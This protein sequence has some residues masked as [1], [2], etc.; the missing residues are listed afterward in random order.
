M[1]KALIF[2]TA[3]L[4]VGTVVA[5]LV[6]GREENGAAQSLKTAPIGREDL[7]RVVLATGKVE[8]LA[9][10]ELKSRASGVVDHQT[11]RSGM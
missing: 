4:L 1:K 6:F 8:P 5:Y 3:A 7:A 2:T 11:F 9:R 10:V